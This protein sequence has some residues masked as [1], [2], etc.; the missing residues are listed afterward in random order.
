[1]Q[2]VADIMPDLALALE[3]TKTLALT[4]AIALAF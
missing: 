2:H 4:Q 3:L 1:M